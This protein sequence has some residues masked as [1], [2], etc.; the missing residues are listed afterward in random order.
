[1]RDLIVWFQTLR[2][3]WH[4]HRLDILFLGILGLLTAGLCALMLNPFLT[5][6]NLDSAIFC[7]LGQSLAE[8]EGYLLT[9]PPTPQ[10]Y[11]TFPPLL[12][13]Q[14][15]GLMLIL[16]STDI[17]ALQ[18][19]F[20]A[21]IHGLFL[22]SLPV[23]Y[24]W[25]RR[26]LG[27]GHAMVL[28]GLVAVNPLMYKYSADVLSDVPYWFWS[29]AALWA[30]S[31]WDE[32]INRGEQS[33]KRRWLAFALVLLLIVLAGL[34]RQIGLALAISFVGLLAWRW[35]WKPALIACVTFA[36]TLGGWQW[37]E[38]TYRT[39]HTVELDGLNQAGVQ[40]FLQ[41]SPIKLEFIKHFMVDE[42]VAQDRSQLISG[43][44]HLLRNAWIRIERYTQMSLDLLLPPIRLSLPGE[45]VNL[46]HL[47][48]FP[49]LFWVLLGLGLREC[50]TRWPLFGGYLAVYMGILLVYPYISP[51]F[52][53]PVFP[54]ILMGVYTGILALKGWLIQQN[55]PA[56]KP[57]A[58]GL[59][60]CAVL[61]ILA[62]G[63]LPQ[64]IRWVHAGYQLKVANE[65]PSLRIQNKDFYEALIWIKDHTPPDSLIVSRKPPVTY[66]YTQ[67]K[68]V[69]F[70]FS[71]Q[72]ER[73]FQ[74]IQEKA[75]TYAHRLPHVYVLE[76]N[77]F[78][79]SQ[80]YLHPA[81]AQYAGE[82]ELVY[83]N[84]LNGSRVWRLHNEAPSP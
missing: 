9:S 83:T 32:R 47:F 81:I 39:Q 26:P 38:H 31:L 17:H 11:F 41:K 62:G 79:E 1:M 46:F 8:G 73:V 70:P 43:P 37:F 74:D 44:N 5:L 72:P 27:R 33:P 53:L 55:R 65:A 63:H 50:I 80:H 48:P 2:Q 12:P 61:L 76:D 49:L 30:I 54:L 78:D 22:L 10:P 75:Q 52:L 20:K 6:V 42:P 21:S 29:I 25:V 34:C 67:R 56:L 24:L 82:F 84:P 16:G 36:L 15:A 3:G 59:V 58:L 64:T 7:L 68:S 66:F 40:E 45:R 4:T 69:V 71:A 13:V 35:L 60:P 28:T 51:R 23:F 18:P 57:L 19:V 14:L 77:A